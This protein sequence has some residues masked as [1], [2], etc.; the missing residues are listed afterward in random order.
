LFI[1]IIDREHHLVL[2][3]LVLV[4]KLQSTVHLLCWNEMRLTI[5]PKEFWW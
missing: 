3:R 1:I 4:T 5:N 2:N